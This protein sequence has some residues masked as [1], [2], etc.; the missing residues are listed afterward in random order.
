MQAVSFAAPLFGPERC[1]GCRARRGPLCPDC[2]DAL[3]PPLEQTPL[4]GVA[5]VLAPW[6]YGG[7]A[8]SLILD[9]K[10]RGA[11]G[12]AVPLVDAMTN[13]CLSH[14]LRAEVATWV[15]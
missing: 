10:L 1:V 11:R 9:L 15:P 13:E 8:R 14:G 7:A 3:R 6:R 12:A 5:R 2:R 4:P